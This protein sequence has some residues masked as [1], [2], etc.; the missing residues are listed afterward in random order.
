MNDYPL[1]RKY[2]PELYEEVVM[3]NMIMEEV[4]KKMNVPLEELV[5]FFYKGKIKLEL[6][7]E[8]EEVLKNHEQGNTVLRKMSEDNGCK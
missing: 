3:H 8:Q 5:E 1:C 2:N 7:N 4:A 6:I